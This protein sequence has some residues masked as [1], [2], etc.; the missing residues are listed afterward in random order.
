MSDVIT[1]SFSKVGNEC[2]VSFLGKERMVNLSVGTL[3]I[4]QCGF[5]VVKKWFIRTSTE[6]KC[7]PS[8]L[9]GHDHRPKEDRIK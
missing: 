1:V 8:E 4:C 2:Q 5:L 7:Q 9:Y 6:R 3:E